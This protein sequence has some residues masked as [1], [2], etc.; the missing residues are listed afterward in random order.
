MGMMDRFFYEG[1]TILV[2]N[3]CNAG[4]DEPCPWAITILQ[5]RPI[6]NN[7]EGTR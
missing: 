2:L 3:K 1:V 4:L 5:H 7:K 6:K